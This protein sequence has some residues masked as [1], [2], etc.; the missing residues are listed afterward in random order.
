MLKKPFVIAIMDGQVHYVKL[1]SQTLL[2][3]VQKIVK[4][5]TVMD[6]TVV[7][8]M[9]GKVLGAMLKRLAQESVHLIA[10]LTMSVKWEHT[11]ITV[12]LRLFIHVHV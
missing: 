7:A 1:Q 3:L 9:G 6:L 8:I 12:N 11:V 5:V 2:L 10:A 4:M